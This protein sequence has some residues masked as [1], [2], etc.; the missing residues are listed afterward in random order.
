MPPPST[1]TVTIERDLVERF[2]RARDE[3]RATGETDSDVHVDAD[4]AHDAEL[5]AAH[6][7]ALHVA[8]MASDA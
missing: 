8:N 1:I 7:L 5:E 6:W 2:K 3:R 4:G